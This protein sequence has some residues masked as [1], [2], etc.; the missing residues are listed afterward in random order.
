MIK[1]ILTSVVVLVVCGLVIAG[2]VPPTKWEYKAMTLP[3]ST[4]EAALNKLGEEGWELVGFSVVKGN[5]GSSDN[6]HYIFK[7]HKRN[8][9]DWK[10]WK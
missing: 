1:W 6:S 7:R 5:P 4:H 2:C 8:R 10:F 3:Y 9:T